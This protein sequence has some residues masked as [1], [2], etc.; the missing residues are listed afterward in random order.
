MVVF[1]RGWGHVELKFQ[2]M[3][4]RP[5]TTVGIEKLEFLG[6]HEAWFT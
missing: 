3:G 6:Y 1:E 2:G 5:P 4:R